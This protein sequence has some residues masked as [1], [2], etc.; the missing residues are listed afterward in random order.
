MTRGAQSTL[1]N[2]EL[3][4]AVVEYVQTAAKAA[5]AG[6]RVAGIREDGYVEA[7]AIGANLIDRGI[8]THEH[9][10]S[11]SSSWKDD[12]RKSIDGKVKR[13]LDAEAAKPDA[14]ILRFSSR[15]DEAP[16]KLD[17]YSRNYYGQSVLYGTPELVEAGRQAFEARIAREHAETEAMDAMLARAAAANWPEPDKHTRLSVTYSADA[18]FEILERM[19]A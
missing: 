3:T 6:E 17:G 14:R 11:S 9:L 16:F 8:L 2:E 12:A 10:Q 5:L 13:L 1:A 7:Y 4:E 18:L 15:T 19:G